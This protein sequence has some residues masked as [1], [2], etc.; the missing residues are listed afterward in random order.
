M[1]LLLTITLV[2]GLHP[3]AASAQEQPP[4]T[5]AELNAALGSG[6]NL[7]NALEAEREGYWDLVLQADY[8]S[9]VADAGF[10]HVRVPIKFSA[11][12]DEQ[13]PWLIPDGID[14]SVPYGDNLWDRI[15]W[16]IAQAE[17]NGLYVI[18]DFHHYDEIHEDLSAHRDR[19]L[20]IWDQIATRY[21]DAGPLVI[22]EVLNE[23]NGVFDDNPAELNSLLADAVAL[24]RQT[25]PT[26]P[27]M[28]G[29]GR[30]NGI[31]A[32][33][34]LVVPDDPNII[35]SVHFYDPFPFTH[36]GAS[37]LNPVPPAPVSWDPNEV[38]IGAGWQSWSWDTEVSPGD[39]GLVV[40][41]GRQF[42][43]LQFGRF[44]DIDP[45]TMTVTMSGSGVLLVR[46]GIN[47]VDTIQPAI[48]QLTGARSTTTVDMTACPA[49][50]RRIAFMIASVP[51]GPLLIHDADVCADNGQCRGLVDDA[52]GAI[53]ERLAEAADWG[54]AQGVPMNLGEY[55]AFGAFGAAPLNDRIIWTRTVRNAAIANGISPSYWEFGAGFG[56][57][58]RAAGEWIDGLLQALV[59]PDG[60]DNDVTCNGSFG[61]DDVEAV[62]GLAADMWVDA[63]SC[64]L[65]PGMSELHAELGDINNDGAT[66]LLDG[67]IMSQCLTGT[68]NAWCSA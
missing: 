59:P 21:A 29:P 8:F 3:A 68:N 26:R 24:I 39:G 4:A 53:E 55:G 13:A 15:D 40:E 22:F 50:T 38:G 1:C 49:G 18:I 41:Y 42:A 20:A 48:I 27:V 6:I 11:Y 28:I 16:V 2:C 25:N 51:S 43:G 31:S 10:G 5:I 17:A 65:V 37:W 7:G 61:V 64:A 56:A 46:C 14:P 19:F 9:I 12:A 30:F 52:A 57:Y 66:G 54:A 23:P 62:L 32:L 44:D 47:N 63:G 36:Q 58:D 33:G 35:V 45:A 34:D 60:S 67:L